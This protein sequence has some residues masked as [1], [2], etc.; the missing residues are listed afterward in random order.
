MAANTVKKNSSEWVDYILAFIVLILAISAIYPFI[1]CLN[2]S[3]SNSQAASVKNP[4]FWPTEF[5][6]QNYKM[7]FKDSDIMPAF[8]I[9]IFRTAAGIV[10][11]LFVTGLA[12]YAISKRNMPGNTFFTYVLLIP[13]Y[14]GGGMI[15]TYVNIYQLHLINNLLVY[16]LPGGFATFYMLIM[17]TYFDSLP[18]SIEESARIDGAKDMTIFLKIIMPLSLPIIATVALFVGVDQWNAWY[19]AMVYIPEKS[20]QPIQMLLQNILMS[21]T[22]TDYKIK[23]EMSRNGKVQVSLQTIQMATLIVTTL[24][25]VMVYPFLQKY[26]IKGMF[27]GAV[28]G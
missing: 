12:S 14:V 9:S 23:A 3:L 13:M 4:Y 6:L 7:V 11:T 8:G 17:R 10:Y 15:A 18:P 19:D 26:F 21:N 24:P 25:I 27:I 20:R 5:T 1:F 22:P 2:Y 28:K 16:I